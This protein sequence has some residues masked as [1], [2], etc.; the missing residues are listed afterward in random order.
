[1]QCLDYLINVTT[2]MKIYQY[3]NA[4]DCQV[5]YL[6]LSDNNMFS[7][8][9]NLKLKKKMLVTQFSSVMFVVGI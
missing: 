5:L 8:S 1:M 2:T 9:K 3:S 4:A 7:P 6:S